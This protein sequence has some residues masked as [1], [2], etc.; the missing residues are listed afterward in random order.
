MAVY[1]SYAWLIEHSKESAKRNFQ[2]INSKDCYLG[3][4]A[5]WQLLNYSYLFT[6][7]TSLVARVGKLITIY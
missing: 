6:L 2:K 5:S 3:K 7:Y 4:F 1:D